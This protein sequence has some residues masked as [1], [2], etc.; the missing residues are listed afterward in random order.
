MWRFVLK[1]KSREKI[2][3]IDNNDKGLSQ[4]DLICDKLR[5]RVK[6]YFSDGF[7]TQ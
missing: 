5:K 7:Y 6:S 1:G 4:K 2:N 3:G